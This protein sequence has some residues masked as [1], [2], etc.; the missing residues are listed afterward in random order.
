M[1]K[2]VIILL[3][4]FIFSQK[5]SFAQFSKQLDSLCVL[6]NKSASDSE[7]VM[8]L[9]KLADYYYVYKLNTQADSVLHRQLL[10]A[11]LSNNPNLIRSALFG[12]AILN[13]GSA[14]SE[15]FDK[16]IEFI[17][18]G[19]DYA[20]STNQY[21]YL[22]LG[23][24]RMSDILRRRGQYDKALSNSVSALYT[25]QNVTSDSV[26]AITYMGLGDTY[27][28]KGEA[29]SACSNYNNAFDIAVKINSI[30]LQSKIHHCISEMYRSLVDSSMAL[31]ELN[32]S[33]S[34]NKSHGYAE[35]MI[36]DYFDLARLTDEKY[37]IER[38]IDLADS[39]NNFKY[40]LNAKRLMLVYY[41]YKEKNVNKSLDYLENEPDLKQSFLNNGLG[42]YFQAKGNCFFYSGN[43]DSS[44]VYYKKAEPEIAK[45]FDMNASSNILEQI[46]DSY[47]GIKNYSMAINYYLKSLKLSQQMN[48]AVHID[49]LSKKLSGLYAKQNDFKNAFFY[50]QQVD[51]YTTSLNKLS[52][53]NDIALLGVDRENKKHQ[54]E[55]LQEQKLA[56][57][58]R[59]IQYM[60]ITV[61]IVVVFFLML[62]IGSF[63]VSKLTVK[64]MGYFFFISLFEFIVLL[65]DNL[66][67]T[68]ATHNQ[69]LIIWL[70]KIGLIGLL[71]PFQHFL[72]TNLIG[73]LASRKL[74]EVRTKF[75]VKKWWAKIKKPASIG[76]EGLE[77]DAAVL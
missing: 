65:I 9:G 52:K 69:P 31:K 27:L 22:A 13:I 74:I 3:A 39:L 60:A 23:Y 10:I 45:K 70:I 76:E 7:K 34:L 1:Q 35:G 57:N 72:E 66:F 55:L 37:F 61:A 71:V 49:T 67:L 29:I 41:Y 11:E 2:I 19:I 16:T 64:L 26:K 47:S 59:N 38:T 20:R 58:K 32:E 33:L 46:G 48:N 15:S 42:N 50:A 17:Q 12:D 43:A 53:G 75:S 62:F 77:E 21:D 30:P 25:L 36:M 8:A 73:L 24:D 54:Q 4:F 56:N 68:H 44:L 6:C 5:S 63:P 14:T 18:K 28:G 40:L 51:Y